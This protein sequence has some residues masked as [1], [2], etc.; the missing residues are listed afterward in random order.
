[1]RVSTPFLSVFARGQH[2]QPLTTQALLG[3]DVLVFEESG[4][5]AFV[6]LKRDGY[7]GYVE[8]CALS[9]DRPPVTQTVT[10]LWTQIYSQASIKSSVRNS[11]PFGS[12]LSGTVKDG[13][14]QLSDHGW[15]PEQHVAPP[16][17]AAP[18]FVAVALRMLGTPYLWGGKT[19]G[20]LDC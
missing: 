11:L 15:I 12:R 2:D 6:Q 5:W 7:V 8:R 1:M 20:G 14:L 19:P 9:D 17:Q 18:D 3:E 10:A 16:S 4:G 13:F